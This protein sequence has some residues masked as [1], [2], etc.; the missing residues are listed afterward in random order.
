[1]M[2]EL[3][4]LVLILANIQVVLERRGLIGVLNWLILFVVCHHQIKIDRF[5]AR[6][7]LIGFP[8]GVLIDLPLS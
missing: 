5:Y 3:A 7:L 2:L 8:N 6:L 4:I 1:M